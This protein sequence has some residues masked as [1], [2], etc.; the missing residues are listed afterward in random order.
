MKESSSEKGNIAKKKSEV[1]DRK[2]WM[3]MRKRA[4]R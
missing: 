3:R 4:R 1:I 2:W